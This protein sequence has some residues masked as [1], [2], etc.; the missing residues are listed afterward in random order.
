MFGLRVGVAVFFVDFAKGIITALVS[1]LGA[2]VPAAM[3]AGTMC[4]VGHTWSLFLRFRGGRGEATAI[5]VLFALI[6][7]PMII[8]GFFAM[9]T[10]VITRNLIKTSAVLLVPLS[11]LCWLTGVSGQLTA[12]SVVLPCILGLIYVVK[13]HSRENGITDLD[14]GQ[15]GKTEAPDP[16]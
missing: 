16:Y 4:V 14:D 13:E 8:A 5:G 2:G 7:V 15:T 10:L 9:A 1:F 3:A 12:Y 11:P 6:P